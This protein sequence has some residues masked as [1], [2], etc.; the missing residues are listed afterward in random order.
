MASL[1]FVD[2]DGRILSGGDAL[3]AL[4]ADL[5]CG[6]PVAAVLRRAQRAT[7][8]GYRLVASNRD[9]LGPL[10]PS[11]CRARADARIER[12]VA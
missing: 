12:R 6:R 9:R 11:G 5:P 8:I 1:H 10:I 7:D 2:S 3:P 4:I